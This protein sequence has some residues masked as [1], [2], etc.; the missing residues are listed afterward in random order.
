MASSSWPGT[1]GTKWITVIIQ[2]RPYDVIQ[3]KIILKSG[4]NN[5]YGSILNSHFSVS[6]ETI[7]VNNG[8]QNNFPFLFVY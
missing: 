4:F 6:N 3:D 8:D 2:H 1:L 7:F 5:L